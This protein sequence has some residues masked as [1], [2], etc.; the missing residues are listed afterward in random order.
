[1]VC[2]SCFVMPIAVWVWF[3]FIMPLLCKIK[4]LIYPGQAET[5]EKKGEQTIEMQCPFKSS[6]P[7]ET[8]TKPEVSTDAASPNESKKDL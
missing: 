1:M 3:Q 6:K 2:V 7:E 8:L 4:S 5:C